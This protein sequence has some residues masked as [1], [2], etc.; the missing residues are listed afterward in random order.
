MYEVCFTL[1][2]LLARICKGGLRFRK[3]TSFRLHINKIHSD[4]NKARLFVSSLAFSLSQTSDT[5]LGQ[6]AGDHVVEKQ[7]MVSEQLEG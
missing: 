2:T 3:G 1:L 4:T 7:L 6:A 5:N